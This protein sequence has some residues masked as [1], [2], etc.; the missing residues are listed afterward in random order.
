MKTFKRILLALAVLIGIAVIT[1]VFFIRNLQ[2]RAM[3]DYDSNVYIPGIRKKVTVYRDSMGIPHIYAVNEHDLYVTTG[4]IMAQERLWQMDL[5]RRVTTG[6]LSEIFGKD[7]VET[8]LLLRALDYPRKSKWVLDSCSQDVLKALEAFSKGVNHYITDYYDRLPPEFT[9]LGYKPEPWKKIH[10]VNLIGYMAWDLELGWSP[11]TLHKIK[12]KID[13]IRFVQLLP[14][15]EARE[16]VVYPDYEIESLD[17][18]NS[19]LGGNRKLQDMQLDIL[20]GSNNWSLAGSKTASGKPILANDMHIGLNMPGIWMQIHQ[21]VEP[22]GLNVTGVAVP[23]QPFVICGHNDSIAWGMTNTGVDNVDFYE[24]KINEDTSK[25]LYQGN[26]YDIEIRQESIA[27]KDDDTINEVLRYTHRGPV[28][29]RFKNYNEKIITMHWAGH[30]YSNEM[31]T[32]FQLNRASSWDEFL[33]AIQTFKSISQNINYADTK[34]NIGLYCAAG[35][36]VRKR[37]PGFE[38]LPGWTDEFDWQGFVP[39]D[40]L[41]FS[42]NPEKG[43]VASANSKTVGNDYPYHIG[44]WFS[45][46]YRM[47]RLNE[48]LGSENEFTPEMVK[49]VQTDVESDLAREFSD[50]IIT[51]VERMM[52]LKDIEKEGLNLLREWDFKMQSE[53]AAPLLFEE[54]YTTLFENAFSDELGDSLYHEFIKVTKLP[55]VALSNIWYIPESPW[56]DDTH[57]SKVETM[58]EILVTTFRQV[59]DKLENQFG[60]DMSKWSWGSMHQLTLEHP[61]GSVNILNRF[62]NLNKGPFRVGGSYHTIMPYT[63]PFVD[64]YKVN[65]GASQRHIYDLNDWDNS[66]SVIPTGVSGLPSSRFYGN[67][68]GMYVNS[69]YHRDLFS[70]EN[71]MANALHVQNYLPDIQ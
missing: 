7:F 47:N 4:Y 70:K 32:I 44:K 46:P 54:L 17:L 31:R 53:K 71:V 63:Y 27:T 8:D 3:P 58:N 62:F 56:W 18:T 28:V 48:L 9:I 34:G 2:H 16:T 64:R 10:S 12:S 69:K 22:E 23:G 35:V 20:H 50:E 30:E 14:D 19:I 15:I 37:E 61:L 49:S 38:I 68:T 65:H 67:Q 33:N 55:K 29:N 41:P 5:L 60:S 51:A 39:F 21:Q 24:E 45:M 26:W 42:F 1:A 40:E 43:F 25:Y 57:T 59:I 13:S 11:F 52:D 6:R 36:P 66:W